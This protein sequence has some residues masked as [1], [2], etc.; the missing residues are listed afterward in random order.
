[1]GV[2]SGV[3]AGVMGEAFVNG[4][5]GWRCVGARDWVGEW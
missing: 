4:C 1:M 3:V 2:S 5:W